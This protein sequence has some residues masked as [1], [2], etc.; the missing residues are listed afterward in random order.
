MGGDGRGLGGRSEPGELVKRD[1]S[2]HCPLLPA[3]GTATCPNCKEDERIKKLEF[4]CDCYEKEQ[5]A[6]GE[7]EG[8]EGGGVPPSVYLERFG[9]NAC[10]Q[11]L[12][13]RKLREIKPWR[14]GWLCPLGSTLI[15][16]LEKDRKR[17]EEKQGGGDKGE[18]RT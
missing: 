5:N 3:R 1:V 11:T 10:I 17:E 9:S 7:V 13:N 18:R 12:V 16:I 15:Q 8:W 14:I 6:D 2:L 4:G